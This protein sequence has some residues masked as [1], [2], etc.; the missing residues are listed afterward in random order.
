MDIHQTMPEIIH[1]E[2]DAKLNKNLE[3]MEEE[4]RSFQE[5]M[6]AAISFIWAN[7]GETMKN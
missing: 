2:M 4:I 6:R 7:L 3:N 1:K 5:D